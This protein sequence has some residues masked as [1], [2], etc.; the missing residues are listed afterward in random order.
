MFDPDTHFDV[1]TGDL[2]AEIGIDPAA[3]SEVIAEDRASRCPGREQVRP[4]PGDR[5]PRRRH[6]ARR[7]SVRGGAGEDPGPGPVAPAGRLE[8]KESLEKLNGGGPGGDR[9][10]LRRSQP[11]VM[12]EN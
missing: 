1:P 6:A 12:N 10:G 8:V 11:I 4:E 9:P 3:A 7:R 2:L 5:V